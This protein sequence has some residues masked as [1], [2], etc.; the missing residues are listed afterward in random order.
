MIV[1]TLTRQSVESV[2]LET[3]FYRSRQLKSEANLPEGSKR[4]LVLGVDLKTW[5]GLTESLLD[6]GFT[7]SRLH[8]SLQEL[9]QLEEGAV[10]GI[11]WDCESS[12]L[13]GFAV[14]SRLREKNPTLPILVIS[15]PSSR[16]LLVQGFENG[17]MDFI[18]KPLD[19]I[20]LRKKCQRL[21][22]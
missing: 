22:G 20:E 18:L 7:L 9:E 11:L 15:G 6:L 19:Q 2:E 4:I 3:E 21:F 14:V 12:A 1:N 5:T 13:K 8:A 16:R 17:V 10:D